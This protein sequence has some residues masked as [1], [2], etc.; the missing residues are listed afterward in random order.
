[1]SDKV[2]C[3]ARNTTEPVGYRRRIVRYICSSR[4]RIFLHMNDGSHPVHSK[5][6]EGYFG[7]RTIHNV[8]K[9][10]PRF[11]IFAFVSDVAQEGFPQH[12]NP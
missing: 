6:V 9:T 1:M 4:N 7:C 10:T 12:D 11:D 8:E 5:R 3:I 2:A